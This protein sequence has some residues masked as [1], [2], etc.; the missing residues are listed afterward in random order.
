MIAMFLMLMAATARA[1]LMFRADVNA[2]CLIEYRL[3]QGYC[4]SR[5]AEYRLQVQSSYTQE[6]HTAADG[7]NIVEV[8][9][10][11]VVFEAQAVVNQT[12]AAIGNLTVSLW[13]DGGDALQIVVNDTRRKWLSGEHL[14]MMTN[15]QGRCQLLIIPASD[16]QALNMP[17]VHAATPWMLSGSSETIMPS[18][19]LL[20]QLSLV[21]ATKLHAANFTTSLN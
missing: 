5:Q 6:Y 9:A 21:D 12:V 13:H 16:E 14:E 4:F 8:G 7:D 20:S 18:T 2:T 1:Q 11:K 3:W 10:L 15:L 17:L 19:A